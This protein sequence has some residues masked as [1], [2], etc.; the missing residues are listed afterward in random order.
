MPKQNPCSLVDNT[1][2]YK[3]GYSWPTPGFASANK[4]IAGTHL[5]SDS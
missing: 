5:E 1:I 4:D 3:L 2:G